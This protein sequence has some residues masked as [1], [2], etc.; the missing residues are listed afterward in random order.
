M[1]TRERERE[2]EIENFVE[3]RKKIK[4]PCSVCPIGLAQWPLIN[5]YTYFLSFPQFFFWRKKMSEILKTDARENPKE[6]NSNVFSGTK[7]VS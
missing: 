7:L 3:K 5:M 1:H 2:N 4:T 6:E